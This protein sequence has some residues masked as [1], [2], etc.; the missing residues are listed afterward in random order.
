MGSNL[1]NSLLKPPNKARK[2]PESTDNS[3]RID[4]IY[5]NIVDICV[6]LG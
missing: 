4:D 3:P 6:S 2:I 5:T 1:P